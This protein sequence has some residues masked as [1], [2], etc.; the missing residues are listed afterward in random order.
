MTSVRIISGNNIPTD[1]FLEMRRIKR[2]T[3]FFKKLAKRKKRMMTKI[4]RR[5]LGNNLIPLI[6]HPCSLE[7]MISFQDDTSAASNKFDRDME[8]NL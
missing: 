3:S 4:A 7:S 6:H 5:I 2:S 1:R 8:I